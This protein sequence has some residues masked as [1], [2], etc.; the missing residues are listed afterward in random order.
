MLAVDID[1]KVSTESELEKKDLEIHTILE[2]TTDGFYAVNKIWEVTYF[3]KTAEQVLGCT[4]E[5]IVGKNL[6][7]FFLIPGKGAFTPSINGL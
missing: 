6:W 4:R 7:Q 3:N 5:E 2:S 1:R